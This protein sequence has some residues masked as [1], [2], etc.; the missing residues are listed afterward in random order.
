MSAIAYTVTATFPD[1]A[2]RDEYVRWL[3][4]GHVGQ[5]VTAG[6]TEGLV[7]VIED[8]SS[9]MQV[10]SRYTFASRDALER[11]LEGPAVRLRTE[12]LARFGQ[13]R[14]VTFKRTIGEIAERVARATGSG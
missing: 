7:V 2:C 4:E 13:G 10:E 9:P 11:Y 14:G 8:P 3:G 1:V 6:A 5:V 12:G